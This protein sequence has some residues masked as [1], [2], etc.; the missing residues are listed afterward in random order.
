MPE[1]HEFSLTASREALKPAGRQHSVA[2]CPLT[3][4]KV[5]ICILI[6]VVTL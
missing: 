3:V 4:I 5:E 1:M 6:F 2:V